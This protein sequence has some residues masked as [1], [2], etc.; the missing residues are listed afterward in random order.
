MAGCG[1]QDAAPSTAKSPSSGSTAESGATGSPDSTGSTGTE[2]EQ[3]LEARAKSHF[4]P[5]ETLGSGWRRSQPPQPGFGLT[6]CGVDIE[7]EEARGSAR[8]RFAQSAVG[9]FL[10]QHVQ[11]HRDGLAA[12][13]VGR[14]R[15]ALPGCSSFETRGELA[16]GPVTS[17]VI[18]EVDFGSMPTDAVVWRMTS[19]GERKVTQDIALVADGEFLIG[20]VSYGAGDPPD[21]SIIT[22]A[23]KGLPPGA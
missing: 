17:F 12:E 9:P 2:A 10:A 15:T 13:V 19:Q 6:V 5:A 4:I 7:P 21:P 18:D 11:A 23:V 3:G 20:F 14:L 1:D 22:K 8:Q 16:N